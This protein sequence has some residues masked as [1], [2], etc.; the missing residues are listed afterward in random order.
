MLT[1]LAKS[2]FLSMYGTENV[3]IMLWS[4]YVK[5]RSIIYVGNRLKIPVINRLWIF[6]DLKF[7]IHKI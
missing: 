3:Y 4:G 1:S 7:Y 5:F 6:I 2:G